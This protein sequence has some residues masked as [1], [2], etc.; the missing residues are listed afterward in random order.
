M[1]ARSGESVTMFLESAIHSMVD[2][3]NLSHATG[4]L[5][6]QLALLEDVVDACAT[7]LGRGTHRLCHGDRGL[8]AKI[9]GCRIEALTLVEAGVDLGELPALL[10]VANVLS[11]RARRSIDDVDR[12]RIRAADVAADPIGNTGDRI[13]SGALY[14]LVMEIGAVTIRLVQLA[15]VKTPSL[16]ERLR[17]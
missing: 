11:Q 10:D 12:R 17:K 9:S 2:D 15:R 14:G 5:A 13:T 4:Y 16:R 1:S 6:L 3:G 8:T 7:E